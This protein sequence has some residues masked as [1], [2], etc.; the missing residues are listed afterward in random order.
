MHPD[1]QRAASAAKLEPGD[2]LTDV[3][4]AAIL[5]ATVQTL[6]NWRWRGVGPR[7]RKIGQRM[8]RYHVADLAAFVADGGSECAA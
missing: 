7:W 1:N 8:V 5:G 3:E 4:A 6:R 2:L